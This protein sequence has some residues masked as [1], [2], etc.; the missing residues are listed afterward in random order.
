[1]RKNRVLLL[2]V[3]NF[4]ASWAREIL[5]ACADVCEF[6]GAVDLREE[7]LRK[8]PEGVPVYTDLDTALEAVRPDLVLNVTPPKA[9]TELNIRLLERGFAVAC[10]K[11]AADC[12]E[13]AARIGAYYAEHGGFLA[14]MDD[15][16]YSPVFREA[17]KLLTAGGLGSIRTVNVHFRH[18][19]PDYSA[20]YHGALP[21]PL[22]T[23]VTIHHLDV[24]RYLTGE[25]PVTTCCE[26]FGAPY[27]WYGERPANAVVY[28]HMTNGVFFSYFGTLAA[29]AGTTEWNANWEIECDRGTL[30]IRDNALFL[31]GA[32]E[33]G[34]ERIAFDDPGGSSRVPMLRA[35]LADLAAGRKSESDLSENLKTYRWLSDA[36]A[37]AQAG[38]P[39]RGEAGK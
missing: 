33:G 7:N 15:Y 8:V 25:E 32:H 37:S 39:A 26:S 10:E 12:P 29:Y 36:I 9:H 30:A 28:S 24:C 17:K 19:H 6:A 3:G 27:A 22:L 35:I 4:G 5:P 16:R 14:I 34:C 2:G 20:F 13:N 21:Q 1:M 23:D 18:Y 38:Q 11:P 31:Y